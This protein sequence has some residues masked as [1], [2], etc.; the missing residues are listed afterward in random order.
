MPDLGAARN[1][2][3]H[4]ER[5]KSERGII[6]HVPLT[7]DAEAHRDKSAALGAAANAERLSL[8]HSLKTVLRSYVAASARA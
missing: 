5:S 6:R 7:E 1:L 4:P 8:D 3:I 2:D